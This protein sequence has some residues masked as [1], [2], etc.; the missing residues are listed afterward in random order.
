MR[1]R[2]HAVDPNG[3][4]LADYE[5]ECSTDEDAKRRACTY[6]NLH[7]VIEV[8]EGVRRVTRLTR[9]GQQYG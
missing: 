5:F 3:V 6:L 2:A 1:Y 7:P 4:S 8:W 9:D